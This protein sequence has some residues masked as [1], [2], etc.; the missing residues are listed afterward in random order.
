MIDE[1]SAFKKLAVWQKSL[2]FTNSVIDIADKLETDRKHYRLIEQ[3]EAAA[4]SIAMN[5]AE[6][7]GRQTKKEF[8][9]FLFIARGSLY[10]TIT[11][12]DIFKMRAWVNPSDYIKLENDSREIAR[13]LNGLIQTLQ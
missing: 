1:K 3:L 6:G 10:E 5:I 8:K 7:C 2:E 13:M 9:Q 4:T 11:L 12:L